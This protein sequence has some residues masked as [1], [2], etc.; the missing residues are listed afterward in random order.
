MSSVQIP[1][2]YGGGC[3][4]FSA[5]LPP[6][7]PPPRSVIVTRT[8]GSRAGKIER[9]GSL[10]RFLPSP[11]RRRRRVR[12]IFRIPDFSSRILFRTYSRRFLKKEKKKEK[13]DFV[14]LVQ[15]IPT[16]PPH[17]RE[18]DYSGER[19]TCGSRQEFITRDVIPNAASRRRVGARQ[20]RG[21]ST[22]ILKM[23]HNERAPLDKR[24]SRGE[25]E[26]GEALLL[27]RSSV[28]REF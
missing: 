17:L 9:I 4:I 21:A 8:G 3:L 12:E 15:A 28:P 18:E 24:L 16:L 13:K 25:E 7:F 1:V 26:E 22:W 5:P 20:T 27:A 19:A 2:K 14:L 6:S 10:L 11:S 23:S